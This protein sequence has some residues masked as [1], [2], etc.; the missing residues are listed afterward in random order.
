VASLNGVGICFAYAIF[1]VQPDA[2]VNV[3]RRLFQ[4]SRHCVLITRRCTLHG[5][6]WRSRKVDRPEVADR[7]RKLVASSVPFQRSIMRVCSQH[8]LQLASILT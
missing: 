4:H 7:S 8:S 5:G 2:I 1:K 3:T 6:V